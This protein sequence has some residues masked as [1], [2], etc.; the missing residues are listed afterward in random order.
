MLGPIRFFSATYRLFKISSLESDCEDYGQAVK[1]KG[2]ITAAPFVFSLD[3]HHHIEK[4]KV[5]GGEEEEER[6]K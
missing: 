3:A 4:G 2:T 6:K 1:Y 5:R